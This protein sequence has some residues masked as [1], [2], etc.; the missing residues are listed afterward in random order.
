VPYDEAYEQGFEDMMRR[1]P[2]ISKIRELIGYKPKVDLD[3]MLTTIIEYHRVKMV[4]EL[5][6]PASSLFFQSRESLPS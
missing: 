4:G 2:D 1:V 5:G 6:I 3:T